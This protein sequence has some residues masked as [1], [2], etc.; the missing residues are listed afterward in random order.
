VRILIKVTVVIND[1][2]VS[3]GDALRDLEGKATI[4]SDFVLIYG[5]V[6]SNLKLANV[7]DEHRR[8]RQLVKGAVMT[9]VYKEALPGHRTRS[10]EDQ[11]IVALQTETKRVV[12]HRR[13]AGRDLTG[14]KLV[15]QRDVLDARREIEI[16]HDLM[17][18][19]IA[20]CSPLVLQLMTDNFDYETTDDL[21]NGILVNEEVLDMSVYSHV[22]DDVEYAARVADASTYHAVSQDVMSRWAY[23][24]VPD[25]RISSTVDSVHAYCRHCVYVRPNVVL[26]RGARLVRNVAVGRDSVIGENSVLTHSVIGSNCR[27]GKNVNITDSYLFDNVTVEDESVLSKVIVDSHA[28]IGRG[29]SVTES[30]VGAGVALSA[31][32]IV[33][34]KTRLVSSNADE[35]DGF[36]LVPFVASPG[37]FAYDGEE[38]SPELF[39]FSAN[40]LFIVNVNEALN[41]SGDEEEPLPAGGEE[42]QLTEEMAITL[43]RAAEENISNENVIVEINSIKHA[44]GIQIKDLNGYLTQSLLSLPLRNTPASE[45]V[46]A[47]QYFTKFRANAKR[48]KLLINNYYRGR[49]SQKDLLRAMEDY[50]ARPNEPVLSL[51]PKLVHLLYDELDVLA[52]PV[53]IEWWQ[54]MEDDNRSPAVRKS[55]EKFIQWLRTADEDDDSDD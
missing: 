33:P 42:S 31:Q 54:Q 18:C 34:S 44:Y 10:L 7:V 13:F 41:D 23:P 52:E 5:D 19:Y 50:A 2:C 1:A 12:G 25:E 26:E 21:V 45:P 17:D 9:M 30:I 38:D 29:C 32:V 39:G 47:A 22:V 48:F 24:M 16:R 37:L 3:V 46:S 15:L 55:V 53:I 4:R 27:I 43:E 51:M 11:L 6:V 40:E 49:E 8:R 14:K 36:D 28:V 20:V 35:V